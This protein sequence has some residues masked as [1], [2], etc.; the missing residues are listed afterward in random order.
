M[1]GRKELELGRAGPKCSFIQPHLVSSPTA[2]GCE[3]K[4][5]REEKQKGS[6]AI[7]V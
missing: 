3:I 5:S 6:R 4:H 1:T 2:M 7:I